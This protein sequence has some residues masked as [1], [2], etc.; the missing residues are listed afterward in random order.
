[1]KISKRASVL[2]VTAI[3]A[4]A[5]GGMTV[6]DRSGV[7]IESAGTSLLAAM[8]ARSPGSREEGAFTTKGPRT[9]PVPASQVLSE[10][11]PAPEAAPAPVAAVAPAALPPVAAAPPP[12]AAIVPAVLAPAAI[13]P[14]VAAA[15]G[16]GLA[17]L[18]PI[19]PAAALIG[20]GG[21]G[22]GPGT[23]VVPPGGGGTPPPPGPAIP[24]PATWL[25]MISGFAMLGLFLRRRRAQAPGLLR[26]SAGAAQ[27]A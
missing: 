8:R 25:M 20:G 21:G 4:G 1:M 15:S 14:A 17:A 12:A 24:E 7:G 22:G 23:L 26:R 13:V 18:L 9:A 11:T 16:P 10:R 27:P 6:L 3:A 2:A 19:L 5:I